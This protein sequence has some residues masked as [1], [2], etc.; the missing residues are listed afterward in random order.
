MGTITRTFTNNIG[1]SGV[2]G[3]SAF[4]NA[5]VNNVTKFPGN[6][7]TYNLLQTQTASSD[8]TVTFSSNID[9]TYNEYMFLFVNIH[10]QTEDAQLQFQANAVGGSGFNE[11]ITDNTFQAY[12]SETA[13]SQALQ[14]TNNDQGNGTAFSSLTFD[15]VGDSNDSSASGYL[16][17]YNPSGTTHV[18]LFEAFTQHDHEASSVFCMSSFQSGYFN[19]TAAIDEIQFK[20]STGNIDSGTFKLYG[21]S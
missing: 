6:A 10:P 11:T 20:F 14:Y 17:L 13:S 9:S 19:T 1:A 21:V 12:H 5:S 8:A 16:R 15:G 4:N 3:T 2:L 7:V 18:K